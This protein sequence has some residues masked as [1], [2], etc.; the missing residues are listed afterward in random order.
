[1]IFNNIHEEDLELPW[2]EFEK[3]SPNVSEEDYE[4]AQK[5]FQEI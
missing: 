2:E 5:K 3:K 4:L 1:M